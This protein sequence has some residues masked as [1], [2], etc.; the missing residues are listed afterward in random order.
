MNKQVMKKTV[1]V[2]TCVLLFTTVRVFAQDSKGALNPGQLTGQE[3]N[4]ITTA[5]PFLSIAPDSRAGAM[6]DIGCAT[7][8]DANSQSY[9]PAKYVFN[10]NKFGFSV[11]YSPWLR[12][13]VNDINHG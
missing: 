6:G 4:A 12:Q 13:L 1:T 10:E 3:L 8:A 7:S 2:L 5:V 9:N 11:S